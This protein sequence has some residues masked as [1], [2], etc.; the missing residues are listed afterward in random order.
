MKLRLFF[1]RVLDWIATLSYALGGFTLAIMALVFVY[2]VVQYRSFVAGWRV[3]WDNLQPAT[4]WN[5]VWIGLALVPTWLI[6]RAI[7]NRIY[8]L[9]WRY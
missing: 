3:V 9:T 8:Y 5:P 6:T 4:A 7:H 1:T 2:K